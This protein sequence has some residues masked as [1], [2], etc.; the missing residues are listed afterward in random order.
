LTLIAVDA[1]DRLGVPRAERQ[2]EQAVRD[3]G[4][5]RSV[6][7]SLQVGVDPLIVAGQRGERVDVGLSD[8]LIVAVAEVLP[9]GGPD[10]VEPGENAHRTSLAN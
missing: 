5:E 1:I 2:G 7:R 10:L 6:G 8:D 9:N 3:R 4:A